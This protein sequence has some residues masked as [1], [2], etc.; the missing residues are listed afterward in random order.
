MCA[1]I[2]QPTGSSLL[3][4]VVMSTEVVVIS[5]VVLAV[6]V[7]GSYFSFGGAYLGNAPSGGACLGKA[8]SGG[9]CLGNVPSGGGCLGNVPSVG[10]CLGNTPLAV[11]QSD[12]IEHQNAIIMVE[13]MDRA[14]GRKLPLATEYSIKNGQEIFIQYFLWFLYLTVSTIT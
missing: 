13:T 9:A 2:G 5:T 14:I 1:F 10:I 8:P 3:L 6:V 4:V 12:M 7:S 11:I